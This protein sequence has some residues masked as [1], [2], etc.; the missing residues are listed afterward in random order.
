MSGCLAT[1]PLEGHRVH[2]LLDDIK[3]LAI[4]NRVPTWVQIF[5]ACGNM[6][7]QVTRCTSVATMVS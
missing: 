1:G 6:K 7:S 2:I 4:G 5:N 3:T